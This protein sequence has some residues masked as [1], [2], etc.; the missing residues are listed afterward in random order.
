[1]TD[2]CPLCE[3][4]DQVESLRGHWGDL[5]PGAA[6]YD[7]LRQPSKAEVNYL[8]ALGVALLG[9]A[10]LVTGAVLAG[11]VVLVG[12][13]GWGVAMSRQVS[14]A[15]GKRAVWQRSKWCRRCTKEFDPKHP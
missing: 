2:E 12:G 3:R 11:V 13:T 5:A 1:M 9:V 10:L 7:L 6:N 15:D 8:Y 4:D 14:V